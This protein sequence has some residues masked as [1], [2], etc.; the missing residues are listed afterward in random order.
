MVYPFNCPFYK[1]TH[2]N[3]RL[4]HLPQTS[5]YP[6][7]YKILNFKAILSQ[8]NFLCNKKAPSLQQYSKD[9]LISIYKSK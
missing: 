3:K 8:N 6:Y 1:Q 9:A 4:V 5:I 7:V 2:I